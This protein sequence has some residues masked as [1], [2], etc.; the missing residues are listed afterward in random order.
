MHAE[1]PLYLVFT[2][3]EESAHGK[4]IDDLLKEISKYT[5][6]SIP[7][8]ESYL[9][10]R[11]Y[12]FGNHKRKMRKYVLLERRKY[13]VDESFPS[14]TAN[15]FP[16]GKKPDNITHIEYDID[17]ESLSYEEWK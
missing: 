4:S 17:L 3:L 9:K 10:E 6:D 2:R 16:D 15:S 7:A 12:P 14:I 1:K 8:Y 11:G 13:L 5:P